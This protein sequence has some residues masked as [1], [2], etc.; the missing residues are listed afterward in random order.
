MPSRS[1]TPGRL[2]TLVV[3]KTGTVTAGVPAVTSVRRLRYDRKR[4]GARRRGG[5]GAETRC[6][7]SR[8]RSSRG[9]TTTVVALPRSRVSRR[10]PARARAAPS[11]PTSGPR[12]QGRC[13]FWSTKESRSTRA[14]IDALHM[15]QATPLVVVAIDGT[16]AGVITLADRGA[17]DVGRPRSRASPPR[18]RRRDADGRQPGDRRRGRSRGRHHAITA[19]GMTPAAKA[20]GDS[21]ICRPRVA[22]SGM[23]GDGVNDAPALAAAD[24]SFAI[25]AG[26]AIAIEAAD[27]TVVRDDLGAVV[28]AILLSR[29]TRA[30]DPAEP[31]LRFRLQRA[32]HSAGGVRPAQSGDRRRGDGDELGVGRQ[33]CA[34]VAALPTQPLELQRSIEWKP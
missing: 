14:P 9:P 19:A 7:R 10:C 20:A 25:G 21:A 17:T 11:V 26:S 15:R 23:V 31:V 27:V 5:A 28:D 32:R 30:Q 1:R 8:R 6:I 33:Q 34:A 2:T 12:S 16:L 18:R 13:N 24:V 3:D 22:S 4:R 29:A